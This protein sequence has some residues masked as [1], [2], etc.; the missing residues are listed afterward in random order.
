MDFLIFSGPGQVTVMKGLCFFFT[1]QTHQFWSQMDPDLQIRPVLDIFTCPF[2]IS[3]LYFP[4]NQPEMDFYVIFRSKIA[5]CLKK[6]LFFTL[7][8][9]KMCVSGRIWAELKARN[10]ENKLKYVSRRLS[11]WSKSILKPKVV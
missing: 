1:C 6:L 7:N 11:W 8:L 10:D 5:K 3:G 9:H 4:L 2:L